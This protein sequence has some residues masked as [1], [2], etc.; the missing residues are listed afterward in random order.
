[1]NHTVIIVVKYYLEF[2]ED[3][4]NTFQV[5]VDFITTKLGFTENSFNKNNR[6]LN[7]YI[8]NQQFS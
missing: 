3:G 8:N 6:N 2:P 5:D 7:E 4:P 1:M